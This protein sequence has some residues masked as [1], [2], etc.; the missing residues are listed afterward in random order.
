MIYA[1]PAA[2]PPVS[3]LYAPT[4]H[5]APS[6]DIGDEHAVFQPCHGSAPDIAGQGIA[7]PLA[8]ILSAGMMLTWLG[9]KH[10]SPQMIECGQGIDD[11]VTRVLAEKKGLTRDLGGQLNTEECARAV[12]DIFQPLDPE[13]TREAS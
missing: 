4:I 13:G 1:A 2:L 6:A 8:M 10:T 12:L 5:L 9:H 11:S 3:S 7:N